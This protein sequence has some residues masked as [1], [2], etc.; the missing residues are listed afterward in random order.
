MAKFTVA[1]S[2]V[3]NINA[4]ED[5]SDTTECMIDH[6]CNLLAR[7]KTGHVQVIVSV[8]EGKVNEEE[9]A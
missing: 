5:S 3:F 1:G 2:R 6:V 9:I 4:G 7:M 8:E